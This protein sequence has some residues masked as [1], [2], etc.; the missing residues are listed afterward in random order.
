MERKFGKRLKFIF[1]TNGWDFIKVV[2][3][4]FQTVEIL[5]QTVKIFMMNGRESHVEQSRFSFWMVQI[6]MLNSQDFHVKRSRFSWRALEIFMLSG[7]DFYVER[8][9]FLWWEIQDCL[10]PQLKS[11]STKGASRHPSFLENCSTISHTC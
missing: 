2:E 7:W 10:I 8:S 9:R 6:F 4:L 3:I 11:H 1:M 5:L